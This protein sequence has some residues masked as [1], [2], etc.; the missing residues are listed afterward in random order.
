MS[1]LPAY[2]SCGPL[3]APLDFMSASGRTPAQKFAELLR[4][5][6]RRL[7][8]FRQRGEPLP[9]EEWTH[10]GKLCALASRLTEFADRN[11]FADLVIARASVLDALR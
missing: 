2:S 3:G 11:D 7:S 9:E 8:F 4:D 10:A 5:A 1:Q 6:Y